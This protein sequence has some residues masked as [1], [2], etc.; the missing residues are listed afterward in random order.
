MIGAGGWPFASLACL[1]AWQCSREYVGLLQ[2]SGMASGMEPPSKLTSSTVTLFCVA[3]NVWTAASRGRGSTPLAV[4][5]F[6]LMFMQLVDAHKPRFAQLA[7]TVFGLIYCGY[8][9]SFWL[10]LR[11]LDVPA[12]NSQLLHSWPV[13]LGG[14]SHVTVGLVATLTTVACVV[15][16]DTGAYFTGRAFGRT[17]LH[18]ISPKKTVEG[19]AGGLV[20]SVAVALAS[21]RFLGW[22]SGPAQ[23]AGLGALV[24]VSSVAGDLIESVIKRDAG[25]KDASNLIPGHGG[26]L[27]RLDSYLFTGAC[28][29]F[30]ITAVLPGFGV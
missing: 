28:V 18:S 9:P 5:A 20:A 22:P 25:L 14:L 21:W 29:Y 3:L 16:A 11:M 30:L 4:A 10:R 8:L 27:D 1:A 12:I 23:A 17:R 13:S 15:G 19:A 2:A 26:L 6:C 7:S 24:F